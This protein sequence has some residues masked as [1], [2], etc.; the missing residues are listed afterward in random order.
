MGHSDFNITM[1]VYSKLEK[2][3]LEANRNVLQD[4]I[5]NNVA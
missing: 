2:S 3:R 1:N 4:F 5:G